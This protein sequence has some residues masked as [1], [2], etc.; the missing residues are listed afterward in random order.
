MDQQKSVVFHS[1]IGQLTDFV[2][3]TMVIVY[4]G[5]EYLF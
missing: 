1:K 3:V 5:D 2:Y 4:S